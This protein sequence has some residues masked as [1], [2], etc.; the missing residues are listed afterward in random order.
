MVPD[1]GYDVRYWK[2]LGKSEIPMPKRRPKFDLLEGSMRC[3][4]SA[5]F[6]QPITARRD[7]ASFDSTNITVPAENERQILSV[8]LVGGKGLNACRDG[9]GSASRLSF[10]SGTLDA[11]FASRHVFPMG[12]AFRPEEM[13][14]LRDPKRMCRKPYRIRLHCSFVTTGYEF[15][16]RPR[17]RSLRMSVCKTLATVPCLRS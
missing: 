17:F 6:T 2:A 5:K 12:S 4:E 15:L 7:S 14:K 9:G 8:R 1:W 11:D 3:R 16:L 10:V 13:A